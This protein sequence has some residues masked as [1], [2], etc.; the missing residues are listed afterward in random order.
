MLLIRAGSNIIMKT[1]RTVWGDMPE[2]TRGVSLV[3]KICEKTTEVKNSPDAYRPRI[4]LN[5]GNIDEV[6]DILDD[7]AYYF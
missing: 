3:Q 5:E 1:S 7:A 6:Q 4:R 2:K